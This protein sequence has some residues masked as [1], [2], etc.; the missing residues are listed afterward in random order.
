MTHQIPEEMIIQP[1]DYEFYRRL[2]AKLRAVRISRGISPDAV[3]AAANITVEQLEKYEN[4][5]LAIPVYHMFPILKFMD[6]P[7]ELN[8]LQA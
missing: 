3:A 7:S 8:D 5:E 1:D 2:G 6:Y 4:A